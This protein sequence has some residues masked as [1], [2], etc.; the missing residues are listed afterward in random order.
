MSL[1]QVAILSGFLALAGCTSPAVYRPAD[2]EHRSGYSD[3]RIAD[4]RYRVTFRGNSAT[5]RETV[6]NYLLLR[7]AEVTRDAGY[8]WFV[9]DT[10][11][12]ES[13]TT[14]HTDF[15]G[16]PGWGP[17]WRAGFGGYWHSWPYGPFERDATSIPTTRYEAY[18]E[19]IL[20]TPDQA[21][22][23]PHAL[24]ADDVITRLGP[25][26]VRPPPPQ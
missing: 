9:F 4:N 12:T 7:A 24:R 21:K 20:L 3:E 16:W 19:I 23:D 17:G 6:E 8:G 25:A 18:A 14:Y 13:K 26:A 15:A 5:E 22:A 10:R 11:N 1:K 2:T